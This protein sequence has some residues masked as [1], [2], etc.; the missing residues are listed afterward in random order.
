MIPDR[1][2]AIR[3]IERMFSITWMLGRLC[4]YDCMYCSP[5]WH[6]NHSRPH[7]LEDLQRA[8]TN[9]FDA[10]R[11]LDLP[12]KI[13]FTGGEVTANRSFLPFVTW[14]R[15]NFTCV[16]MISLTTNGSASLNYYRKLAER[17]ESMSFSTHSEFIDEADFFSKVRV[18]DRLM[19][20][21]VKSFHVNIMDEPW[22]A[23]R[24]QDYVKFCERYSISHSVNRIDMQYRSKDA[25]AI[26]PEKNLERLG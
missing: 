14:L 20:R 2:V 18:L 17:V 9:T 24:I 21:P 23:D 16:Q 19:V 1:I 6:D 5:E 25:H 26:L 12:Y 8:W 15:E 22:H 7:D 13:S 10:S 11:H 4:N 3:P